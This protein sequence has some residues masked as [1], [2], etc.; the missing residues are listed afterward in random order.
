MTLHTHMPSPAACT[1]SLVN[2][3]RVQRLLDIPEQDAEAKGVRHFVEEGH[4]VMSFG[5]VHGADRAALVCSVYGSNPDAF[6]PIR[7]VLSYP[8]ARNWLVRNIEIDAP[9]GLGGCGSDGWALTFAGCAYSRE[10]R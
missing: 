4:G 6:R 1:T 5:G 2:E 9:T 3:V 7:E 10:G 8:A